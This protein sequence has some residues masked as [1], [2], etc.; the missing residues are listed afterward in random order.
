MKFQIKKN[1]IITLTITDVTVE[2]NGVG[3]WNGVTVFVPK[4]A[5]GDK[6][7]AKII[8]IKSNYLIGKIQKILCPSKDRQAPDCPV[9]FKCGGCSFRHINYNFELDIKQKHVSDCLKR[10]GGFKEVEIEKILDSS[11][12]LNYRNKTQVPF[13]KNKDGNIVSGFYRLHSHN[14]MECTECKL[15]P[16][17]FDKIIFEIKKWMTKY[18]VSSYNEK[19]H[20]GCVRH[21]YIR[22]SGDLSQIMVCMVIN[23]KSVPY[24][25]ELIGLL[26]GK[27]ESIKGIVINFNSEDTNVI[28]GN[29]F[30]TIWG[31]S[32]IT[33]NLCGLKFKISPES[34][35]Q[36]N[37]DQ[38]QK[39]YDLS[40]KVLK[41][42]GNEN[43]LDLYCGIGTIGLTLSDKIKKLTGVEIINAA[44]SNA[45]ENAR[46]NN[47]KNANFICADSA[48]VLRDFLD[49]SLDVI[50]LDPPRKG[51]EESVLE[52]II[53]IF[54]EKILYISC[55][56]ATLARDLKVLCSKKYE[57]LTV[58]PVDLFPRTPHVETVVLLGRKMV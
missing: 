5:I 11:K 50:I 1:D 16:E 42:S 39:L 26:T 29:K 7:E 8:K 40:K 45:S 24:K 19:T 57:I 4:C 22:C 27:F 58:C 32:Y 44:I 21:V 31:E 52:D 2:G 20:K 35:Y 54:P 48:G 37:H 38:T 17:I 36:I 10:I 25:S 34:F 18:K 3:K 30:S 12:I 9:Y 33:D 56:P 49:T 13:G 14:I 43:V 51:C 15:H 47:I 53:K 6:I 46:L 28:L 41:L 55:N 23:S